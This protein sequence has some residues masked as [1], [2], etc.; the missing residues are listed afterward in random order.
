MDTANKKFFNIKVKRMS[1]A[2]WTLNEEMNP[3]YKVTF[4]REIDASAMDRLRN[5]VLN[6]TS[7]KPSYTALVIKA[8]AIALKEYPFANRAILGYSFWKRFIQFAH[9]DITVAVERNVP[10][11]E[12]I[13]LAETIPDCDIKSL[14]DL[15]KELINISNATQESNPRWRLFYFLLSSLPVFLTKWLIRMPKFSPKMWTKHRGCACFVNSPAKYGVDFFVGDM[16]WPLTVSF[17]W[18][19]ER[20]IAINGSVEVRRTVP[21]CI[22]FDRRIMAGAPAARFFSRIAQILENADLELD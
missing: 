17:G 22:I 20:P 7:V 9:Y 6:S 5:K 16:L 10:D 8:A 18:V 21:L 4:L 3:A 14:S 1:R 19:K 2:F 13:V 11:A 15:T 12:S